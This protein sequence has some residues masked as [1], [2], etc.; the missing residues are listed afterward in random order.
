MD[1]ALFE[2][3]FVETPHI[4]ELINRSLIYLEA[5]FP[6][7]YKGPS[8]TGKTSLAI[9]VAKQLKR[10]IMLIFGNEEL[11]RNQMI[12]GNFGLRKRL[13]YDNYIATV[14][15]SEEEI[16]EKWIDGRILHAC[17]NGYTLIYDEFTRSTPQANNV[18]LSMLEEGIIEMYS[19]KRGNEY[20]E[21]HP[22]FR[23]IFTSNPEEYAG[24]YRA[25]DALKDRMITLQLDYP[26]KETEKNIIMTQ[27][28][29]SDKNAEIIVKIIREFR[30]KNMVS[31]KPTVRSGI[32]IGKSVKTS[33][34][35]ENIKCMLFIQICK[36]I[37]LSEKC[38]S[39][40]SYQEKKEAENILDQ[41]IKA[42]F[43]TKNRII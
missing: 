28:N 32:M 15:K 20:V 9:Y 7:H 42:C 23:V 13:T 43:T 22:D 6:I 12:G 1:K 38:N 26:D 16:E 2:G 10:P 33:K 29:V 19:N 11:E 34:I 14:V 30:K 25:Q 39:M 35:E 31:F 37:I 27:S 17:K 4:K 3:K 18:F 41:I 5:G 8:G 36:D 24:V 40:I 21:V